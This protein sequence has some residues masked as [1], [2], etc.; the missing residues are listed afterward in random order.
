PAAPGNRPARHPCRDR[1][2]ARGP[3][4]PGRG[5][6]RGA[7]DGGRRRAHRRRAPRHA[8]RHPAR[9]RAPRGAR[10]A[11][12]RG[13]AVR[14]RRAGPRRRWHRLA[15]L[16]TRGPRASPSGQREHRPARLRARTRRRAR[17]RGPPLH[18]RTRWLKICSL[19]AA[20]PSRAGFPSPCRSSSKRRADRCF[21]T[22]AAVAR[23][24]ARLTHT[25][26]QVATYEPYVA[27]AERLNA[28]VPGPGPKKTMLVNTG[29]EA[30]ENAVKIARAA[31][32]RPAVVAFE[33]AFHGRTLLGM[34]LTGKVSP[35]KAGFGPFAP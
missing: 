12:R 19:A 1:A 32:G 24:A 23:Q 18:G 22:T 26:F 16:R 6:L 10:A 33:H 31:T 28:I 21:A 17:R 2:A 7:G 3:R 30:V 34:T 14:D 15:G 20:P 9:A 11:P 27:L 25:C 35:Y 29:A 8:A 13:G 5:R 4:P